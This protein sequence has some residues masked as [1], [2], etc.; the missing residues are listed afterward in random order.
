MISVFEK[1]QYILRQSKT[2]TIVI[3]LLI[4]AAIISSGLTYYSITDESYLIGPNPNS[5]IKLV[6]LDLIIFL[7]LA[8]LIVRKI[9]KS[10]VYR[11]NDRLGG[12]LR[13]RVIVMFSLVAAV[14]TIIISIFSS[15]FFN[16][17]LQSWFNQRLE[18]ML[19]Y[20]V[21][22]SDAYIAD[23]S[24][25]MKKTAI[26]IAGDLG[27][28]YYDFVHTPH[29]FSKVLNAQAN[30][31]FLDEAIIFQRGSN[32]ILAK[33]SMSFSLA[34]LNIPAPILSVADSGDIV[35]IK[36]DPSRI[37]M[38]IKL[39][40]YNDTYL[41]I[42][43]MID[44]KLVNYSNK[45]RFAVKDY[46]EINSNL[47][48]LQIQFSMAFI[49]VAM[50]LLLIAIGGG[51][52]FAHQII[53]PIRKLLM[54]TEKL[55]SGDLSI[56]VHESNKDDELSILSRAFNEMIQK[57][58]KQQKDLLIAQRA[59]AW[60]D[61]A[62]MV[63]H[64][65]KNPLTPIQLASG[66]LQQ[67][68]RDEVSNKEA[69]DKYVQT[70]LR[71][72]KDIGN[73]LSEFVNL[74]KMPSPKLIR[75][76]L[77]TLLKEII[78]S[79]SLLNERIKYTFTSKEDFIEFKCDPTQIHQVII[80]LLKNSEES[81]E[82]ETMEGNIEIVLHTENQQLVIDV[83]DDG[84]GFPVDIISKATEPYFTTRLKGTGLGLAIVQKI[85]VDHNGSLNINNK[86]EGGA[87]IQLI[88]DLER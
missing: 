25:Q 67:K 56:R 79:R 2:S 47:T 62:R 26:S 57:L 1:L 7:L 85:V 60:S 22:L 37:R 29:L 82:S 27:D 44:Q 77:V 6:L 11:V 86:P 20:S 19:N 4:I 49:A 50:L 14:P 16:F 75:T 35:E 52:A 3:F 83:T 76:D 48:F 28:M 59:T 32:K 12:R 23:Q 53:D 31:R 68:F 5:I 45:I 78:E 61:V 36:S 9:F 84:K 13:N 24:L 15:Y 30:M 40:E 41:L 74:A 43:K 65:I 10:L 46:E 51:M 80:N 63:A 72:T 38:L 39:R 8:V 88:F 42:G 55:Q 66:K 87:H 69:F 58:E 73:I 64:E 81:I 54:A 70:I 18:H 34:F 33:T 17:G 21:S 71:H